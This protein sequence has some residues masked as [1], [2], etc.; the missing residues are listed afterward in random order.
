MLSFVIAKEGIIRVTKI[1]HQHPV[2]QDVNI[3]FF[4]NGLSVK[5]E[6]ERKDTNRILSEWY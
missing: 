6:K 3:S 5:R 4:G 2:K 1:I